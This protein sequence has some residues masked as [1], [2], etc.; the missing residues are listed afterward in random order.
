MSESENFRTTNALIAFHQFARERMAFGEPRKG[1]DQAFAD[2]VEISPRTW[3]A[4]KSGKERIGNVIATKIECRTGK[5]EGWLDGAHRED[6]VSW[7]NA[8]EQELA[9]LALAAIRRSD[10]DGR[11]RLA[12][13]IE[14]FK[15]E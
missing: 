1:M 6:H 5:P 7:L 14:D 9:A 4:I 15:P 2:L 12:K 8:D 3:S 10:A 13:M 11:A